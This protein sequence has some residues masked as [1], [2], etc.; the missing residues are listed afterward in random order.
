[1]LLNAVNISGNDQGKGDVM[2]KCKCRLFCLGVVLV[3]GLDAPGVLYADSLDDLRFALNN[4][5]I[6]CSGISDKLTDLKR[7]AGINTAVTGVGTVTG[8]VAFGA[9]IAKAKL[10]KKINLELQSAINTNRSNAQNA[11]NDGAYVPNLGVPRNGGGMDLTTK[12]NDQD[13]LQKSQKLGDIRTGGIA[14]AGA[15]NVVGSVIASKNISMDDLED[16]IAGCTLAIKNLESAQMQVR[17][18]GGDVDAILSQRATDAISKC[19]QLKTVDLSSVIKKAKGAMLG[20]V[21]G[22]ASGAVGTVVSVLANSSKV[23]NDNSNTGIEKEKN[24]NTASNVLAGT[25]TVASATST[26]FNATQINAIKKISVLA[27]ECEGA[28]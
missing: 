2:I 11:S 6:S 3:C 24:L 17:T 7:M 12:T 18:D 1:M 21:I 19:K 28:F 10:D 13:M 25:T 27:E 9:G 14:V 26:V 23:R 16:A 4:A 15:T 22:A 20:S 5:K 8:G